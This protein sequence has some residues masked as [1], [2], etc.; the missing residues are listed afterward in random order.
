M[1]RPFVRELRKR[2]QFLVGKDILRYDVCC[3]KCGKTSDETL[4]LEL[5]H[6]VSLNQCPPERGFNPNVQ[7]NLLTLCFDCHLAYHRCFEDAYPEQRV[8]EWL[9]DVPMEDVNRLLE[10]YRKDRAA[11]RRF[12]RAKHQHKN[13]PS[14]RSS[15]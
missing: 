7:G 14:G 1:A 2:F 3:A 11:R 13:K 9:K 5:H 6:I 12:H 15:D 4:Q 8:M 10:G